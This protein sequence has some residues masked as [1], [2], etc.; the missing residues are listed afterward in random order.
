[1]RG[2]KE[3]GR[4]EKGSAVLPE[5]VPEDQAGGATATPSP[6]QPCPVHVT[7]D[8]VGSWFWEATQGDR[9]MAVGWNS[10]PQDSRGP[11]SAPFCPPKAAEHP[12]RVSPWAKSQHYLNMGV[13]LGWAIPPEGYIRPKGCILP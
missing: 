3:G 6:A 10:N 11:Y 8:P 1:M 4:G 5:L 7:S 12:P 9:H 13:W 2:E